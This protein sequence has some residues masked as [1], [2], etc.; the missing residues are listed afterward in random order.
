MIKKEGLQTNVGCEP[1]LLTLVDVMEFQIE[2]YAN[3]DDDD[4]NNVSFSFEV[5]LPSACSF[6]VDG[7]LS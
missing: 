3:D 1:V 5:M 7:S 4:D 2:V 6:I